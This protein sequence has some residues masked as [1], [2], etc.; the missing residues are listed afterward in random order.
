MALPAFLRPSRFN[1]PREC[2]ASNRSSLRIIKETLAELASDVEIA[3][4][5]IGMLGSGESAQLSIFWV[6]PLVRISSLIRS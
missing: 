3:A 2:A 1:P 6:P 5:H 4:I